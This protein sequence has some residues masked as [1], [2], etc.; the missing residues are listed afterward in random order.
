VKKSKYFREM[1]DRYLKEH[2][3]KL[4]SERS[5]RDCG[6]KIKSSVDVR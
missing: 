6:R 1:I 3:V 4:R 2:V 5:F